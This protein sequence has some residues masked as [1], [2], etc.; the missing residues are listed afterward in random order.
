METRKL[1]AESPDLPI[2]VIEPQGETQLPY[3]HFD[4]H[5]A[6][7]MLVAHLAELG[8]RQILWFGFN[9]CT[10]EYAFLN[11]MCQAG[12]QGGVC[13]YQESMI[14]AMHTPWEAA[15]MR[16]ANLESYLRD[17]PFPFTAIVTYNDQAAISLHSHLRHRL[18]F[19]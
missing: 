13:H 2:V 16:E 9:Q 4:D 5:T 12:L 1:L 15:Q 17:K 18:P 10:R 7:S 8:H 14:D 19:Y 11:A 3:L 6:V